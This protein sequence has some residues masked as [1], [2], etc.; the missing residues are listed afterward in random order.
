MALN[1]HV[2]GV[3]LLSLVFVMWLAGHCQLRC[4]ERT[5]LRS[6]AKSLRISVRLQHSGGMQRASRHISPSYAHWT[7]IFRFLVTEALASLLSSRRL[8]SVAPLPPP[9][10]LLPAKK[11]RQLTW[12]VGEFVGP[13]DDWFIDWSIDWLIDLRFTLL[14][15]K[16]RKCPPFPHRWY[17]GLPSDSL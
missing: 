6:R 3:N 2:N 5:R 8:L 9:W 4:F 16:L 1:S 14:H 10:I 13:L 12:Q 7:L 17:F 11:S 15:N